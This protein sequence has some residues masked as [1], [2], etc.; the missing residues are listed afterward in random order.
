V[1]KVINPKSTELIVF[2]KTSGSVLK[3]R[4][5]VIMDKKVDKGARENYY[6]N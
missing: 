2:A 4:K 5:L 3:I 1:L 6:M